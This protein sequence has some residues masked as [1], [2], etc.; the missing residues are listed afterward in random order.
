MP[1]HAESIKNDILTQGW[2]IT[3]ELVGMVDD[4]VV[5]STIEESLSR[6]AENFERTLK[7]LLFDQNTSNQT[8]SGDH[9]QEAF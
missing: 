3:S 2:D 5:M 9:R 4:P 1:K 8:L 6:D 7:D